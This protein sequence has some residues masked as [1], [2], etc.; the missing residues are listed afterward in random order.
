MWNIYGYFFP[1]LRLGNTESYERL[2]ENPSVVSAVLKEL[3]DAG[4]AA[5]EKELF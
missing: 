3:R 1:L 5:G 2:C 4:L